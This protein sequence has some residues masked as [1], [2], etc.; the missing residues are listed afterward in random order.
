MR[1]NNGSSIK[2]NGRLTATKR[3]GPASTSDAV[4]S[5][6]S[7]DKI[8]ETDEASGTGEA[9]DI[10]G[11]ALGGIGALLNLQE[12]QLGEQHNQQ[13]ADYGQ[14]LIEQLRQLQAELLRGDITIHRLNA[15][16]KF[17]NHNRSRAA[18]SLALGAVISQIETRVAV[19]M[20]KYGQ[21]IALTDKKL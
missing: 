14:G 12:V 4:F 18:H 11:S 9:G 16:Q 6:N 10:A 13:A 7:D 8:E 19:E 2:G 17:I 1:I 21:D 5:V 3:T 20:A 15:I